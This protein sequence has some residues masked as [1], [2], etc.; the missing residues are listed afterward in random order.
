AVIDKTRSGL[1][2]DDYKVSYL[3]EL[4][5]FYREYVQHLINQGNVERAL[6]IADSSHGR[7]LAERQRSTAPQ[8]L[9]SASLRRLAK[10]KHVVFLSYWLAPARSYLWILGPNGVELLELPPAAEI[11]TLVREHQSAIGNA[12]VDPLA[13]KDAA[14]DK[15]YRILIAPAARSLPRD[16]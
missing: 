3:S 13:S 11:E 16:S 10:D 12:L 8:R 7:V 4:I 15:L 2:K 6:E 1:L 9:S 5:A 14:G